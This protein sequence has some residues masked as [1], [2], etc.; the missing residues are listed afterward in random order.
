[1]VAGKHKLFFSFSFPSNEVLYWAAQGGLLL[2]LCALPL[3]LIF[4]ANDVRK[5]TIKAQVKQHMH[6]FQ[7]L[8]I[9]H[10]L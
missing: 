6:S 4:L 8:T 2:L 5:A 10:S 7:S 3:L 9:R 1:M